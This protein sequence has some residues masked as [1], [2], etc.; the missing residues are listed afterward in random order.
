MTKTERLRRARSVRAHLA[1]FVDLQD[2]SLRNSLRDETPS[3]D[4]D[5]QAMNRLLN[6]RHELAELVSE[7][8]EEG[9]GQ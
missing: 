3:R 1:R 4:P 7:L 8:K 6:A 5:Y 2:E 9:Y